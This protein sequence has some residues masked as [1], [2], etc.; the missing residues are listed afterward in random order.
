MS[1]SNQSCEFDCSAMTAAEKNIVLF[2]VLA[3][4]TLILS[5]VFVVNNPHGHN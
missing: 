1:N 3:A 4:V 2:T 5:V